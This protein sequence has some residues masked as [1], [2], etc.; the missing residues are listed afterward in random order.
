M[1]RRPKVDSLPKDVR[2]WLDQVLID[3]SHPGYVALS[4][5]L[6]E[7]GFDISHAAVHRY[8]GKV[9][10]TIAAV[11]ASTEAA[12]QIAASLPDQTDDLSQTLLRMVQSEMF[13]ILVSLQDAAAEGEGNLEQRLKVLSSATKSAS[14]AARANVT[15]RRW[16]E[17]V[18]KRAAAAADAVAAQAK[19]AGLS[20]DTIQQFRDRIMGI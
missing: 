2:S 19:A 17:D 11:R 5:A 14:E 13:S 12:R 3:R 1:P 10:R 18:R 15:H 8:D 9:Q 20:D 7:R 6:K 16:Q 4:A